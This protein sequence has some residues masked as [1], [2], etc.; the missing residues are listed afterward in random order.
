MYFLSKIVYFL[1][2]EVSCNDN[3]GKSIFLFTKEKGGLLA[4]IT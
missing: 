1:K 2:V 4:H 3:K